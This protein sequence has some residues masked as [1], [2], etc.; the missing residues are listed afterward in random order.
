L[1]IK[2][3]PDSE[4]FRIFTTVYKCGSEEVHLANHK[5]KWSN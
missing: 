2:K 5:S 4:V 3:K 1:I